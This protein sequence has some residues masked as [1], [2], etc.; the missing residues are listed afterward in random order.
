M[1][2]LLRDGDQTSGAISTEIGRRFG[3]SQSAVSQHL[4][5]LKEVNLVS[6]APRGAMRV[7]RIEPQALQEL[8]MWLD[9]FGCLWQDAFDK[10]AQELR[11]KDQNQ[12][13]RDHKQRKA[14]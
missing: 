1:S 5:V 4:K 14:K 9:S 7:Y 2:M 13:S 10:L 12:A 6:S 8:A 3:I 11:P